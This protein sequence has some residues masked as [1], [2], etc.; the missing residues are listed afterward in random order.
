MALGQGAPQYH[1][2]G[3]I[4]GISEDGTQPPT[5]LLSGIKVRAFRAGRGVTGNCGQTA[6]DTHW[7]VI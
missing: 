1:G 5:A 7:K 6:W 3:F 4:Y 2:S